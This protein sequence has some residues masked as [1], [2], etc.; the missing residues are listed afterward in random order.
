[1]D[2]IE[3]AAAKLKKQEEKSLVEKAAE[4]TAT[5]DV[6]EEP[7]PAAKEE[8]VASPGLTNT[9]LSQP[10]SKRSRTVEINLDRLKAMHI[11]TGESE[12]TVTAEEFRLVKRSLLLNAFAKGDK[13]VDKGNLVLVSSSH[14]SR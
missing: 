12:P 7:V 5:A 13:A 10:A 6:T 2:L 14:P 3:K 1:M 9:S 11:L 8:S 4:K